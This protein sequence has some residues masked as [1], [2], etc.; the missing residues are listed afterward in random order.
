M[1]LSTSSQ[2]WR[3]LEYQL[4]KTFSLMSFEN[5]RR[6]VVRDFHS[7]E[8]Q[9]AVMMHNNAKALEVVFLFFFSSR[10]VVLLFKGMFF[11]TGKFQ[12]FR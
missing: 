10:R 7:L 5:H 4:L 9:A 11:H 3:M 1:Q 8:L 6:R 12:F 2:K